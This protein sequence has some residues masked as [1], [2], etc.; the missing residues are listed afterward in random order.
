MLEVAGPLDGMFEQRLTPEK[1]DVGV[2]AGCGGGE[3][4]VEFQA[5]AVRDDRVSSVELEAGVGT[6]AVNETAWVL[7]TDVVVSRC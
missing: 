4:V 5:R 3:V 1:G 2:E 6:G 7:G